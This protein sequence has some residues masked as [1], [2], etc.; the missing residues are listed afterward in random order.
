M[1]TS[2]GEKYHSTLGTLKVGAGGFL[3]DDVIN[4]AVAIAGRFVISISDP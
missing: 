2:G 4:K 3:V 1:L